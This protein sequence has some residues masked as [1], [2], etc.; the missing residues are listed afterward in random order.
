MTIIS[1]L[2]EQEDRFKQKNF[3]HSS[4]SKQAGKHFLASGEIMVPISGSFVYHKGTQETLRYQVS[5]TMDSVSNTN[6][7]FFLVPFCKIS[8]R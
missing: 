3:F 7:K 1:H 4:K 6:P 5:K 2:Q 8:N